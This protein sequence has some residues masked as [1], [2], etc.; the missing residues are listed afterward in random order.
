MAALPGDEPD[1]ARVLQ[2]GAVLLQQL[3]RL[4]ERFD[5]R[6]RAVEVTRLDEAATQDA[7][8]VLAE[9]RADVAR[10]LEALIRLDSELLHRRAV[11]VVAFGG[12]RGHSGRRF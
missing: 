2:A 10:Y 7:A 12:A 11:A 5:E 1:V 8:Q 9:S 3:G 6:D 4:F